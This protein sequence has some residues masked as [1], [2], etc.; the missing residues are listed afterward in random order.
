[1]PNLGPGVPVST[2]PTATPA[3]VFTPTPNATASVRITNQGGVPVYLGGAN[4]SQFN[5]LPLLAGNR[6]VDLQNINTNVYLAA[7]VSASGPAVV[8][9]A[10]ALPAGAT[11]FTVTT[12][13]L[14]ANTTPFYAILGNGTGQEVIQITAITS[15][16]VITSSAT[17]YDH[18]VSVTVAT[19]VSRAAPVVVQ[20]GVV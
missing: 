8:T 14:T 10:T 3:L 20:A 5:G 2:V 13:G 12:T 19:A 6:P 17:L 16:T 9:T 7:G 18:V 11:A 4:V 15:N 1:M